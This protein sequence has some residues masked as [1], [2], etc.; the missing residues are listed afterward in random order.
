MEG[1]DDLSL[2]TSRFEREFNETETKLKPEIDF[3]GRA[4]SSDIPL[5]VE[6]S[7]DHFDPQQIVLED[8][9]KADRSF[10]LHN[11]L[12]AEECA[13][14]RTGVFGPEEGEVAAGAHPVLW[15]QWSSNPEKESAKLGIRAIRSSASL[16]ETLWARI[17]PYVPKHFD[18]TS[19]VT[20]K[21]SRWEVLP[22][23]LHERQRFVIY[24]PGQAFPKHNDAPRVISDEVRSHLTVL[25]Y[26]GKS[27]G[28][29][30]KSKDFTGGELDLLS[31]DSKR[32]TKL[33]HRIRPETGLVVVFPHMTLHEGKSLKSGR[34]CVI[35]NDILYRLVE[36]SGGAAVADEPNPDFQTEQGQH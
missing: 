35:R 14:L 8:L 3:E 17:A 10:L 29:L 7:N 13:L 26:L 30:D 36:G 11:V 2:S 25:F 16:A 23:G 28:L 22:C 15:R 1:L 32:Q 20:G 12:S 18:V 5:E 21:T 27:G 9:D 31:I 6:L 33:L 4:I 24:E 34:K 19:K